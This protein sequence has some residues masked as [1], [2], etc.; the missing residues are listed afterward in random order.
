MIPSFDEQYTLVGEVIKAH[1][2]DGTVVVAPKVDIPSLFGDF[3]LFWIDTDGQALQP[4]RVSSY[5]MEEK[6]GRRT[7]FVQFDTIANRTEAEAFKGALIYQE[8]ALIEEELEDDPVERY[9]DMA[10]RDE[11]GKEIGYVLDVLL[12]PAHPILVIQKDSGQM[13]VPAVEEY[14]S[15]VDEENQRMV[16]HNLDAFSD[17]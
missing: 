14:I 4:A 1:G 5:R 2:L 15:E 6:S 9:L 8:S 10:V 12:N 11:H 16:V 17:S 13:M 3:D 7:F